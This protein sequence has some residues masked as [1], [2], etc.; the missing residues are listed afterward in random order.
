MSN[1]L[2][3]VN[4]YNHLPHSAYTV[5]GT[6]RFLY[7]NDPELGG[8]HASIPKM[9]H[10]SIRVNA[11]NGVASVFNG[12]GTSQV[13]FLPPIE[14][15]LDLWQEFVLE[16]SLTNNDLTNAADLLPA[17]FLIDYYEEQIAGSTIVTT[18]SQHLLYELLYICKD[19]ECIESYQ[20]YGGFVGGF[21]GVPYAGNLTIPAGQSARVYIRFHPT[22]AREN[23]YVNNLSS[24]YTLF[25]H[26]PALATVSTSLS[27][28]ITLNQIDLLIGGTIFE[29]SVKNRL[30]MRA[31]SYDM[32]SNYFEEQRLIVSGRNLTAGVKVN[33]PITE[34]SSMN[35]S[36]I[37][38]WMVPGS[39]TREDLYNFQPIEK[40]DILSSGIVVG[41]MQDMRTEWVKLQMFEYFP[42]LTSPDTNNIYVIS[43]SLDPQDSTRVGKASGTYRYSPNVILEI[44][45]A[46]TG[47]YDIY[48][49]GYRHCNL[50]LK[51]DGTMEKIAV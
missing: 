20:N 35:M 49:L 34:F 41:S 10:S 5:N 12:S 3:V 43:H 8:S 26:F 22:F 21:G 50:V 30:T 1:N 33:V 47:T 4:D 48:V 9:H 28:D 45:A 36:H 46:A 39:S 13:Q 6:T 40:L 23:L 15:P 11:Q 16:L 31:K 2:L 42:G 27:N 18:Y 25:F 44:Q 24:Q 51:T 14:S 37:I 32:I 38:V 7:V 29:Q 19:D 17:Q